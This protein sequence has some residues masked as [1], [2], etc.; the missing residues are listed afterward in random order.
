M[1]ISISDPYDVDRL[2]F[3]YHISPFK[4]YHILPTHFVICVNKLVE[5]KF[6]MRLKMDIVRNHFF[7][8]MKKLD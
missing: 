6:E 7:K 8:K 1:F 3:T 4:I 2:H 5:F